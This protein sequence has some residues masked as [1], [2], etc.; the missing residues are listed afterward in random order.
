[1]VVACSV[2]V[3]SSSEVVVGGCVVV[4]CSVVV[5]QSSSEVVVGGCVV[6]TGG[7]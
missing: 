1:M 7:G 5:S 2:V 3:H 4:A 6:V